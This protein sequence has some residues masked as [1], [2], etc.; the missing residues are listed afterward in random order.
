MM[1]RDNSQDSLIACLNYLESAKTKIG[2]LSKSK[3]EIE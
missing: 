3:V 1:N 2:K